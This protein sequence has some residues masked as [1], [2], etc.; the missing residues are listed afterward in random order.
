VL[1]PPVA[2]RI[3]ESLSACASCARG[4]TVECD[5]AGLKI[6]ASLLRRSASSCKA[7]QFSDLLFP[8]V[9]RDCA[10]ARWNEPDPALDP[11]LIFNRSAPAFVHNNLL[12]PT[13]S[14]IGI[15]C[16]AWVKARISGCQAL[17]ARCCPSVPA[18]EKRSRSSR[19]RAANR[20]NRWGRSFSAPDGSVAPRMARLADAW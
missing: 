19:P 5:G 7:L 18:F 17:P 3:D 10:D 16:R 13:P 4:I 20:R 9:E 11:A 12:P 15:R 8:P 6:R 14:G 1:H 2:G